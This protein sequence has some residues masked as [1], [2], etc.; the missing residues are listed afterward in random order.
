M[1]KNPTIS[2]ISPVYN[3]APYLDVFIQ[4]ILGQTYQN[5]ELLLIT[6]GPTDSSVDICKKYRENDARIRIIEQPY[7][8]GVAKARNRGLESASGRYVMLADSDDY[9][10]KNALELELNLMQNLNVDIVY[11]GYY[12]DCE[13]D[14]SLKKFHFAKR[15]YSHTDALR[16]H[17][18]FHT[19][20]GYPWGKLFKRSILEGIM[21]P[22]DMSNGED[23]VFSFR[24]LC[25]AAN[26]VAFTSRP[27]YYYRIRSD[28]LTARGSGFAERDLDI[29][30]Q[31]QYIRQS[32]HSGFK[33]SLNVF[34]FLSYLGVLRKY[35]AS[36]A[37]KQSEFK[38]ASDV[39]RQSCNSLWRECF[40][41][42]N[43]PRHK[44]TA[45]QYG[46]R[47]Q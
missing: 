25:A 22:E 10:T 23:G 35:E 45:L 28:S 39:L 41:Y 33:H 5:F 43:N 31:I 2:I 16:N 9:L 12:T 36:S 14:I 18:N 44:F 38:D 19:L 21:I 4:S 13:G 47:H 30:K 15:Y 1:E 34:E 11:G 20:Y 17:L 26:G 42:A 3:V 40:I 27:V 7:N 37:D 32:T 46:L 6:D 8:M 24:A 29:I